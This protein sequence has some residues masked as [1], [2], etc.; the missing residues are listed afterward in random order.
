MAADQPISYGG[1]GFSFAGLNRRLTLPLQMRKLI[2]ESSGKTKMMFVAKHDRWPCLI[3]YGRSYIHQ[4][5]AM[6]DRQEELANARGQAFDRDMRAMQLHSFME[7]PFDSSGRFVLPEAWVKLSSVDDRIF[8]QGN[9]DFITLWAPKALYAM[10]PG[11]EAVQA[12]C[13]ALE[14][15]A[16]KARKG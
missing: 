4:F 15:E 14:A 7:V 6:L 16:E 2:T 8:F 9:G 13:A 12:V 5:S 11:F 1:Q 3:G 10:G